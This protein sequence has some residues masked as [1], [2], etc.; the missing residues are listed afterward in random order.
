[1]REGACDQWDDGHR[2][3]CV[4]LNLCVNNSLTDGLSTRRRRGLPPST[5]I[6]TYIFGFFLGHL[7]C[8]NSNVIRSYLFRI[9]TLIILKVITLQLYY[10]LRLV[11]K[12]AFIFIRKLAK[13]ENLI[14]FNRHDNMQIDQRVVHYNY[15]MN[16]FFMS[17]EP[18]A[19]HFA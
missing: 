19:H 5:S 9:Y 13:Y 4:V 10:T 14:F 6:S 17:E 7:F 11:Y 3:L 18:Q 16:F 2:G 15:M 1:M 12:V 8:Q